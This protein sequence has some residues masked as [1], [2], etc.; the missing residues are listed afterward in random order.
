MRLNFCV[1]RRVKELDLR[2]ENYCLPKFVLNSSSLTVLKLS[3]LKLEAPSLSTL[4]SLKVLSLHVECDAKSLQNLISGC[5]IIEELYLWGHGK[6]RFDFTVSETL[7]NLTLKCVDLTDQWLS[8]L[9]SGLPF[10]ERLTLECYLLGKIN[11]RS[12]SLKYFIFQSTS[13]H[14]EVAL[15]LPNLVYLHFAC[16]PNAII[17]VEA[18]NLLEAHLSFF[19]CNLNQRL[20][21]TLVHLLSNLNCS[22]KLTLTIRDER[23]L[24][25]PKRVKKKCASPLPNL[26]H[27][28]VK[29]CGRLTE[30]SELRDSLLWCAPSTET[31]EIGR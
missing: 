8:G 10:L 11:V 23:V 9:I 31:L 25:F 5:P 6:I 3:Q 16:V 13:Y 18:P 19:Y 28:K 17:S 15:S 22:K 26:N 1:Q 7:R 27:L 14:I 20:Y 21:F 4:P 30:E 12:H 29:M 2:F 24:I